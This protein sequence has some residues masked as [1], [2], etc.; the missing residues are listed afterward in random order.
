MDFLEL[1]SSTGPTSAF[2][3]LRTLRRKVELVRMPTWLLLV[4][5]VA[6]LIVAWRGLGRGTFKGD[7]GPIAV[8]ALVLITLV[9]SMAV[10][11]QLGLNEGA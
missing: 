11:M 9:W 2:N 10:A 8:T 6:G 3:P 1:V 4:M 7:N 5:P